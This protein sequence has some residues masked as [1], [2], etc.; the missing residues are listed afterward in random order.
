MS[1]DSGYEDEIRQLP[2]P[3]ANGRLIDVVEL[4][5]RSGGKNLVRE[6]SRML[7]ELQG[8]AEQVAEVKSTS[9]SG[10][11]RGAA[12]PKRGKPKVLTPYAEYT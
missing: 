10:S 12:S 5:A 8:R 4:A 1:P 11:P 9:K 2:T 6:F 3:T 7:V